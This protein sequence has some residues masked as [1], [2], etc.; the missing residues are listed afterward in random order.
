MAIINW[1]YPGVIDLPLCRI[2]IVSLCAGLNFSREIL[3]DGEILTVNDYIAK[4]NV[5]KVPDDQ[6]DPGGKPLWYLPHHLVIYEHKLGKVRV[7]FDCAA[8]FGDTSLNDQLLQG[9]D[10]TNSLTGV[11]LRFRQEPVAL[12]ADVKEMFHQVHVAPD[13]CHALRFL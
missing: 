9:R 5:R 3:Q 10:L 1:P 7:V 13:D 12:M 2:I 6:V 4:G 11:L 8:R